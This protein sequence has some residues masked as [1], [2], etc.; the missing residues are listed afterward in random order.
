M[1]RTSGTM[2]R[3]RRR[4]ALRAQRRRM[5]GDMMAE[6]EEVARRWRGAAV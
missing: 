3:A 4:R 5:T 1:H 2:A 6:A